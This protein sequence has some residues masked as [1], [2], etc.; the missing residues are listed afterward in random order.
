MLCLKEKKIIREKPWM[1][2][3]CGRLIKSTQ[4]ENQF[5]TMKILEDRIK[6]MAALHRLL[7]KLFLPDRKSIIT[8]LTCCFLNYFFSLWL[9]KMIFRIP[10]VS[11]LYFHECCIFKWKQSWWLVFMPVCIIVC[12]YLCRHVHVYAVIVSIHIVVQRDK[13]LLLWNL[14]FQLEGSFQVNCSITCISLQK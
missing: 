13:L 5:M 8:Q 3:T 6:I 7:Q 1:T 2:S 4:Q 11:V 14:W 10:N 12:I 9:T